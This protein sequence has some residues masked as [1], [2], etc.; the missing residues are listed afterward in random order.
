[1]SMYFLFDAKSIAEFAD[2]KELNL[3]YLLSDRSLRINLPAAKATQARNDQKKMRQQRLV[4]M[5]ANQSAKSKRE[6]NSPWK[7]FVNEK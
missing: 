6:Q 4:L 7:D 3:V 5:K 1:M 2:Y